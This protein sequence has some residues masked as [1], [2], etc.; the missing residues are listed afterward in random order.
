MEETLDNLIEDFA[1]KNR[2]N[3]HF[4]RGVIETA[5][6]LTNEMPFN[7]PLFSA[8]VLSKIGQR[9]KEMIS[10]EVT[11]IMNNSEDRYEEYILPATEADFMRDNAII[12]SR[13]PKNTD[14]WKVKDIVINQRWIMHFDR[15]SE[16][17]PIRQLVEKILLLFR[18]QI[19]E[20]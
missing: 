16:D 1:T 12:R 10:E 7:G 2:L 5:R 11:E 14:G 4:V 8:M 19:L 13:F 17:I 15:I 3:G 6:E 20:N 18:P 9:K